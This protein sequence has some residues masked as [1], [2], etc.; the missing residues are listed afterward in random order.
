MARFIEKF[1]GGQTGDEKGESYEQARPTPVHELAEL[2]LFHLRSRGEVS[3][4]CVFGISRAIG[5]GCD[6]E[7][8]DELQMATGG[9]LPGGT[10]NEFLGIPIE[11]AIEKR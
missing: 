6:F 1:A 3:L 2:A 9:E 4:H 5:R 7:M 11:I 8:N 10:H